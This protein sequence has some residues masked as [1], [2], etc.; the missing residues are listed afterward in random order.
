MTFDL[1]TIAIFTALAAP[2]NL[3]ASP[4][5]R[6]TLLM[7]ISALAVYWLRHIDETWNDILG[8]MASYLKEEV[9]SQQEPM[10]DSAAVRKALMMGADAQGQVPPEANKVP[11]ADLCDLIPG[12]TTGQA[13]ILPSLVVSART[14]DVNIFAAHQVM[15]L[16]AIAKNLS[17]ELVVEFGNG[18]AQSTYIL[19]AN[20][21]ACGRVI[22]VALDVSSEPGHSGTWREPGDDTELFFK[23][24]QYEAK[25]EELLRKDL[26][27]FPYTLQALE[28]QVDLVLVHG[29][30]G[31]EFYRADCDA[32][33]RLVKPNG[34][35]LF[36]YFGHS[37]ADRRHPAVA[38][39]NEL[40]A[41]G[42][43]TLRHISGTS[44]VLGRLSWPDAVPGEIFD[45]AQGRGAFAEGKVRIRD[46]V[47]A[48]D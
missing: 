39:L 48:P 37:E 25:I 33:G 35:V 18:R 30:P 21:P 10:A 15:S 8:R 22:S 32:A 40:E 28:G 23:D 47:I 19:A 38:V 9:T 45:F 34:A 46:S 2:Y 29:D 5:R 42:G 36:H 4:Q 1:T 3:L 13:L 27:E 44:L 16:A 6:A 14:K 20:G 43:W 11:S 41:E 12:M 7:M 26:S 24:F 31:R 17:P